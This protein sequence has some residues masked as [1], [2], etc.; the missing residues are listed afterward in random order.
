[1]LGSCVE[2]E[3]GG[4]GRER[5]GRWRFREWAIRRDIEGAE[6]ATLEP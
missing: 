2:G 1:M 5:S 4:D 6:E 3:Q